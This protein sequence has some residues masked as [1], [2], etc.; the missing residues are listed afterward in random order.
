MPDPSA[1]TEAEASVSAESSAPQVQDSTAASSPAPGSTAE[2]PAAQDSGSMLDA[3]NKA[4]S[5]ADEGKSSAPGQG[6]VPAESQPE[7]RDGESPKE[8]ADPVPSEEELKRFHPKTRERFEKLTGMLQ[9]TRQRAERNEERA[10]A[11][12]QTMEYLRGTGLEA[13]EVESTLGLGSLIKRGDPIKALEALEPIY[14]E[15]RRRAGAVLPSDLQEQV[16]LGYLTENHA[17]ELMRA[18]VSDQYKAQQLREAEQRQL[19]ERETQEREGLVRTAVD[20]STQ[21]EARKRQ[22]DPDF[23]LKQER[24]AQ[25]VELGIHRRMR[26]GDWKPTAQDFLEMCETAYKQATDEIR[27]FQPP[28]KQIIPV[29]GSASARSTPEPKNYMDALNFGLKNASRG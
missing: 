2:T 24:V 8:D 27:K 20:V 21:W 17:R 18:R 12:D 29:T 1:A 5:V 11:F 22:A 26:S 13:S 23:N 10:K 15:V 25:L 6:E 3:I 7:A 19:A 14:Q 28:P 16:S 9:E 4:L